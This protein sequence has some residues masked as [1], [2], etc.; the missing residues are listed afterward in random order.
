MHREAPGSVA[1]A[2]ACTGAM[3]LSAAT[4]GRERGAPVI[5][6]L[7]A[8]AAGPEDLP[9][10]LGERGQAVVSLVFGHHL[11]PLSSLKPLASLLLMPVAVITLIANVGGRALLRKT[12]P[13]GAAVST[14]VLLKALG[15]SFGPPWRS[16]QASSAIVVVVLLME[17]GITVERL[18]LRASERVVGT[19]MGCALAV[20]MALLMDVLGKEPLQICSF[21]FAAFT[22]FGAVQAHH[23]VIPFVFSVTCIACAVVIFG[24]MTTGWAFIRSQVASVLVGE[25]VSLS[26]SLFFEAL[27]G[28]AASSRS[29]AHLVEIAKEM[30]DKAFVAIELVFVHNEAA[31]LVGSSPARQFRALGRRRTFSPGVLDLLSHTESVDQGH[32][33]SISDDLGWL[34]GQEAGLESRSRACLADMTAMERLKGLIG[35]GQKSRVPQY[36]SLVRQVHFLFLQACTLAR[37]APLESEVRGHLKQTLDGIRF[38]LLAICQPLKTFLD[39]LNAVVSMNKFEGEMLR[40]CDILEEVRMK[41]ASVWAACKKQWQTSCRATAT[42][43]A[44]RIQS[45]VQLAKQKRAGASFC[46]GF[47]SILAAAANV[48]R[49]HVHLAFSSAGDAGTVDI[50]RRRLEEIASLPPLCQ[51]DD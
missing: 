26:S 21:C 20:C 51:E 31:A 27:L 24:Y 36:S 9:A 18:L 25:I 17:P 2:Q 30:V 50:V 40:M 48:V 13:F 12:L 49:E 28:D 46:Q 6:T 14:C 8:G 32:H 19:C 38:N 33:S 37:N 22:L 47:D 23:G 34:E 15:E 1:P 41:L 44:Q 3:V 39:G 29:H 7:H 5:Y 43:A 11:Q 35:F 16:F 10:W 4:T 42:S 45:A